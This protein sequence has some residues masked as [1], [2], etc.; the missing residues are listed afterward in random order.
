M[1]GLGL[2]F[3]FLFD[4]F[5]SLVAGCE[6]PGVSFPRQFLE[7]PVLLGSGRVCSSLSF[8]CRAAANSWPALAR[9]LRSSAR[10]ASRAARLARYWPRLPA[11]GPGIAGLDGKGPVG[12]FGVDPPQAK[13]LAPR[14]VFRDLASASLIKVSIRMSVLACRHRL[15]LLTRISLTIPPPA[16]WTILT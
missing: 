9:R 3:L 16:G 12:Q 1:T 11:P 4:A 14:F 10:A 7:G 15:P 6:R 2:E 8:T 5:P 13:A